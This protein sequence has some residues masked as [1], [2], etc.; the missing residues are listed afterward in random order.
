MVTLLEG[1]VHRMLSN[2]PIMTAEQKNNMKHAAE[3]RKEQERAAARARKEKMLRLEEEARRQVCMS[4]LQPQ[5]LL[6]RLYCTQEISSMHLL[7][8]WFNHRAALGVSWC[9]S[10]HNNEAYH[11]QYDCQCAALHV[12]CRHLPASL[13][14]YVQQ[15]MIQH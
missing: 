1:D 7:V 15:Q 2:A 12:A 3:E 13:T 8:G 10:S 6:D 4:A 9:V 11:L 14:Y 5:L